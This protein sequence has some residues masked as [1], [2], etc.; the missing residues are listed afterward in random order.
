MV[1]EKTIW[2]SGHRQGLSKYMRDTTKMYFYNKNINRFRQELEHKI[3]VQNDKIN[4]LRLQHRE[5]VSRTN[6]LRDERHK[7]SLR[8][9]T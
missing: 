2:P 5:A 3:Q 7:V 9:M 1:F 6:K 4:N 8:Y